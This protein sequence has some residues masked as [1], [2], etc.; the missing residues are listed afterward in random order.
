[1]TMSSKILVTGAAGFIGFHTVLRLLERGEEV[2]GI[3]NINPYYDTKLKEDRLAILE[4]QSNFTFYRIPIEDHEKVA[5]VF[6]EEN[7]V[8]V[9]HLAAQ[10][11]VRSPPSEFHRYV[12]SNLIGFSNI[13]D[14]CRVHDVHHLVY[15]SS[16]SV[17]G[18]TATTPFRVDQA[19]DHPQNLYAA[20]KRSNE[21]MAYSYSYQFEIPTTGL[22][23]FTV[24]GPWGRPDMAVYKFTKKIA[25]GEPIEV[26]GDGEI[27]RDFTYVDDIVE[28]IVKMLDKPPSSQPIEPGVTSSEV[29]FQLFNIGSGRPVSVNRLVSLIED[30]LGKKAVIEFKPQPAEDMQ[31]THADIQNLEDMIGTLQTTRLEDGINQFVTWYCSYHNSNS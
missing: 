18:H 15:A 25:T 23:F 3:D 1:M 31:I 16:S 30:S 29:P 21:L 7:I 2:V 22:R 28:G 24:Y 5:K 17:Y 14:S 20:T 13:L 10:V 19:A 26:Y 27:A 6:K 12:S 8:R 9:I 11:G 4:R